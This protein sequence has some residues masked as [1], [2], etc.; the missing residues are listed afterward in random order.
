MNMAEAQLIERIATALERIAEALEGT[1]AKA[2]RCTGG[3]RPHTLGTD[4]TH[5]RAC[6]EYNQ[7]VTT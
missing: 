3:G 5:C 7:P 1:E 6:Y 2:D 4:S